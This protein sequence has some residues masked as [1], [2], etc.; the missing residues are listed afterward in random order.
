MFEKLKEHLQKPVPKQLF[1]FASS[2]IAKNYVKERFYDQQY[3][4]Q[5]CGHCS[6]NSKTKII[7]SIG[8]FLSDLAIF[9][10]FFQTLTANLYMKARS[11]DNVTSK[12]FERIQI[13]HPQKKKNISNGQLLRKLAST[14]D[15]FVIDF[16][17]VRLG[18]N[19]TVCLQSKHMIY[20]II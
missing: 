19:K 16:R 3:D 13:P 11:H 5:Y 6:G 2:L 20:I 15:I 12:Q 14:T 1:N 8:P 9:K 17:C 4:L 7:F 10:R 18:L